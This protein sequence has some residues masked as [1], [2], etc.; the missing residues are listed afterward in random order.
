MIVLTALSLLV[1]GFM[2]GVCFGAT[3]V[4]DVDGDLRLPEGWWIL[5]GAVMAGLLVAACVTGFMG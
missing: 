2:L 4:E 3:A 5:P 1:G